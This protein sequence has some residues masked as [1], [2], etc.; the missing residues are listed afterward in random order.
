[1]EEENLSFEMRNDRKEGTWKNSGNK[2]SSTTK[3][4]EGEG[5]RRM[6]RS[7]KG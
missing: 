6:S 3:F 5:A 2:G 4:R 1:V 7:G